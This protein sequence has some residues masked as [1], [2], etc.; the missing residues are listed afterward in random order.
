MK[1][2]QFLRSGAALTV[3][4]SVFRSEIIR[5]QAASTPVRRAIN[6]LPASDPLVASYAK[7]VH[8]LNNLPPNDPRHWIQQANIHNGFCPHQNWW[9]LP[10]HR[11]YLY[12]FENICRDALNDPNF[13]LP[14]WDWTKGPNLPGPFLDHSSPLYHPG[15]RND[16]NVAISPEIAGPQVV[17]KIIKATLLL[18]IFSSPTSRDVQRDNPGAGLFEGTPH[19]GVHSTINGDMN[20]LLS[21]KDPI[22]WLHHCNIDRIWTSWA[23]LNGNSAPGQDLWKKHKLDAFYDVQTKQQVSPVCST[24]L[25]AENYRANYDHLETLSNGAARNVDSS[26]RVSMVGRNGSIANQPNLKL[27]GAMASFGHDFAIG[28]GGQARLNLTQEWASTNKHAAVVATSGSSELETTATYL[29]IE[30]VPM[31]R[32][33]ST[34]LRVFLNC[35]D[36]SPATPLSDPTYVGTVAFFGGGQHGSEMH[37]EMTFTLNV[38]DVLSRVIRSGIY[39]PDAPVDIGIVPVDLLNPSRTA[40]SQ[41]LKPKIVRLVGIEATA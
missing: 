18:E 31:P 7:A 24:T 23:K 28:R 22:F 16:G 26:V 40:D 5:G 4:A 12:Y 6:G 27:F 37:S 25:N 21:P 36:P 35:K 20:V 19:N 9:F 33:A 8:L 41:V 32:T 10:F 2:R 11:A 17:E 14:Y 38:T 3:G 34:A 13:A 15:R 1:R 39:D 30:D 29:V